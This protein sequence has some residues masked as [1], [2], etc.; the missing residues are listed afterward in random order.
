[1]NCWM[2]DG[3][4]LEEA[5]DGFFGYIYLITNLLDGKIYVG[6]KQFTHRKTTKISKRARKATGSR[7]RKV[8]SNVDSGWQNYFGS[9]IPLKADVALLGEE[10]F[11]REVLKFC[12]SKAELTYWEL[13]YQIDMNVLYK[14]SYNGWISGKVFKSTLNK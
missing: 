8:V 6:K 12:R 11:H 9:C 1:M 10:K 4:C 13:K 2:Y 3:K 14:P 5:P 7:K